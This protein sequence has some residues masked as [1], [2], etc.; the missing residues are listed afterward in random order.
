MLGEKGTEP[1]EEAKILRECILLSLV[2]Q[3]L[4]VLVRVLYCAVLVS[5]TPT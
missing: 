3:L 4:S 1:P 5:L 2:R